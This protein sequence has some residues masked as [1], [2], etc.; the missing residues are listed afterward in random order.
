MHT[1]LLMHRLDET[2]LFSHYATEH[3]T[4]WHP[5]ISAP[6][7]EAAPTHNASKQQRTFT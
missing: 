5:C 4:P 1:C 7:P 3:W 6:T 2:K